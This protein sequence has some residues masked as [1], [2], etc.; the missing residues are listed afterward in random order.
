MS[1]IRRYM[2]QDEDLALHD[3]E[4]ARL[5]HTILPPSRSLRAPRIIAVLSCFLCFALGMLIRSVPLLLL[6]QIRE[7]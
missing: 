3:E 5:K 7:N 1:G 2:D 6:K 4:L